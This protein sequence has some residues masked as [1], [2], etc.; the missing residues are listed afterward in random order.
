MRGKEQ[1]LRSDALGHLARRFAPTSVARDSPL[2]FLA[3][4]CCSIVGDAFP[5]GGT[6]G[7]TAGNYW[8]HCTPIITSW[9]IQ[10]HCPRLAFAKLSK[11]NRLLLGRW[12]DSPTRVALRRAFHRSMNL[13][14]C[15]HSH[16]QRHSGSNS[17]CKTLRSR[18]A[19]FLYRTTLCADVHLCGEQLIL[20]AAI[21]L[22][23]KEIA[24]HISKRLAL[25]AW[26]RREIAAFG[27]QLAPSLT[28]PAN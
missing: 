19:R 5:N 20:D 16:F 4:R 14:R 9:A 25:K 27:P 17:T 6:T 10:V 3:T 8:G 28:S 18:I 15:C 11:I 26:I 22:V 23:L 13:S 2:A 12:N 1:W 7:D 21:D 24:T